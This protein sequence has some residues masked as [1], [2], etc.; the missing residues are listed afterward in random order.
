MR[1]TLGKEEKLRHK[2]LV[3]GLF[4]K[5]RTLYEYPLRLTYR[6][7]SEEELSKSFRRGIPDRIGSLQMLITVPKKKMKKAVDR[8]RMRRLIRETYRLNRLDLK[9]SADNSEKIR[10]VSL[11]FIYLHGERCD[12]DFIESKMLKLLDKVKS[13]CLGL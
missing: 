3:D 6:I 9:A 12:Y 5:G 13:E 4:E 7:L 10:T 11:G 8:V 2:N 1:Y